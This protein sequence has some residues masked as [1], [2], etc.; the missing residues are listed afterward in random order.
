MYTFSLQRNVH[1]SFE[2]CKHTRM[3]RVYESCLDLVP[4]GSR[5]AENDEYLRDIS[6]LKQ[7][8]HP[9][10]NPANVLMFFFTYP[11]LAEVISHDVLI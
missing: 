10:A 2:L 5:A 6:I 3:A 7:K 1:V 8:N 4:S 9:D 11:A